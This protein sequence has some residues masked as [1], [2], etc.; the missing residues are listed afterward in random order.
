MQKYY[1]SDSGNIMSIV[2]DDEI[3]SKSVKFQTWLTREILDR[4]IKVV[5]DVLKAQVNEF[6]HIFSYKGPIIV[7]ARNNEEL[8]K[9]MD[10]VNISLDIFPSFIKKYKL[11]AFT[12]VEIK[13]IMKSIETNYLAL[14]LENSKP[15]NHLQ[16]KSKI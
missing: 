8:E 3:L 7:H 9:A 4:Y 5:D 12:E 14:E 10:L 16:K 11:M 15:N 2:I 6:T 13:D 1:K